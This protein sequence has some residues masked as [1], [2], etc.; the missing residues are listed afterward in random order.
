VEPIFDSISPSN[1]GGILVD[2]FPNVKSAWKLIVTRNLIDRKWEVEWQNFGHESPSNSHYC[3]LIIINGPI[4]DSKSTFALWSFFIPLRN[5]Y[6]IVHIFP[7]PKSTSKSGPFWI[8]Q[9]SRGFRAW[10]WFSDLL[11]MTRNLDLQVS[12]SSP[13]LFFL[14]IYS[15]ICF[16]HRNADLVSFS[17]DSS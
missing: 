13:S 4:F 14:K 9:K 17:T 15:E 10:I 3:K 2:F 12:T 5:K 16:V 8:N 7:I 11:L 1:S 6:R